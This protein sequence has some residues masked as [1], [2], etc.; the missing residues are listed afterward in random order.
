LYAC[1]TWPLTEKNLDRLV[2]TDRKMIRCMCG[3]S[4]K[5][6][7]NSVDLLKEIGLVDVKDVVR[8]SRL[9][10]FGHVIRK[11][12]ND[13]VKLCMSRDVEGS[14]HR[15]RPK[16]TWKENVEKDMKSLNLK[17]NDALDRSRWRGKIWG[18]G[19]R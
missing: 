17:E 15:G 18:R 14:R 9:R 8:R 2:K 1:E 5:D 10:W 6:K 16:K 3:I 11:E 13:W 19:Q 4:W 12:D 7:K